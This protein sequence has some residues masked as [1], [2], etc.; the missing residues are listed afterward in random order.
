VDEEAVE[1]ARERLAEAAAGRP[2]PA[3][4]DAVLERARSQ[5]ETLA[6]SAAELEGA[7]PTQVAD[8]VREGLRA[9]TLPVARQLAEVRGLTNQTIRRLERLDTD[10][11]AERYARVDDLALLVDLIVSGWRSLAERL[12]RIE[13]TLEASASGTVHH[14]E[15]RRAGA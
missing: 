3:E 13:Q 7:L 6:Q 5:L 12:D 8:A 9:E 2:R 11:Q 4:V 15:E 10:L 14:L 1:R